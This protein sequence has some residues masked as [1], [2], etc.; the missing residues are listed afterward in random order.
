MSTSTP[1]PVHNRNQ[2]LGFPKSYAFVIGINHYPLLNAH[3]ISAVPDAVAL[4]RILKQEQGFDH[5]ELLLGAGPGVNTEALHSG[6]EGVI[7]HDDA[8]GE[9]IRNLLR[10]IRNA[11][12]S[13][14]INRGDSIV[15]YYAG[16]GKAGEFNQGPAGF[17]LPSDARPERAV[18]ESSSLIPMEEVFQT[19]ADLDCHHTLLILDC[20]FAGKFRQ[21]GQLTRSIGL[22]SFMPMYEERFERFKRERAWQ[23]LVSAGPHQTAADWMGDR[24]GPDASDHSPFAQALIDALGG[25]AE[26]K[27]S[28]KNLGDGVLTSQELFLYLWNQ[29]ESITSKNPDFD[30]QYPDLFPMGNHRGGQFIFFDPKNPL[31]FAHRV[32]RNPYKGLQVFEPEDSDLFF[33]RKAVTGELLKKLEQT[34]LLILTAP[35]ASGKSSLV[36]AGLFPALRDWKNEAGALSWAGCELLVLCPGAKAWSGAPALEKDGQKIK[37]DTGLEMVVAQ[38]LRPDKKQL[39]LIDQLENFFTDCTDPEEKSRFEAALIE[40]YREAPAKQLKIVLTLR[41][42]YEW[43]L[44][45]SG[46]GKA[47]QDQGEWMTSLYRLPAVQ[48]ADLR[49]ALT[50]PA[51]V[52]LFE[53]ETDQLMETILSEIGHAPGALPMLSFTMAQFY[54]KTDKDTR[55]FTP[56]TYREIGGVNGALSRYAD[57]VYAGLSPEKQAVLRK[58]MLRMVQVNSGAYGRRRVYVQPAHSFQDD[59]NREFLNEFDYP[60]HQ[61]ALVKEVLDLLEEKQLI[62]GGMDKTGI[63]LEP[64]HDSLIQHWNTAKQ[65]IEDF[66]VENLN[67][68]RQLWQAV[69]ENTLSGKDQDMG[70]NL[71]GAERN[72]GG[73][74]KLWDTNPK[75]NQVLGQL[76]RAAQP[77]METLSLDDLIDRNFSGISPEQ[78]EYFR[79]FWHECHEKKEFPDL[80]ALIL[81]GYSDKLLEWILE[82]GDHWLNQAEAAFVQQSWQKRIEDIVTLQKQRDE[83]IAD[84]EKVQTQIDSALTAIKSVDSSK[85]IL[86]QQIQADKVDP[87]N[88]DIKAQ[89]ILTALILSSA[90]TEVE[91]SIG[92]FDM[93][94]PREAIDD[95]LSQAH[96]GMGDWV[97]EMIAFK[98]DTGWYPLQK[99]EYGLNAISYLQFFLINAGFYPPR[100]RSWGIYGYETIAGLRLFQEYVRTV[101]AD[102]SIGIPDGKVGSKTWLHILKWVQSGK[103]GDYIAVS[104]DKKHTVFGTWMA[105]INKRKEVLQHTPSPTQQLIE[106]FPTETDTLKLNDWSV[107]PQDVHIIGIRRKAGKKE[108]NRPNDDLFILLINGRVFG[109]WGSTDP[110]A[111]MAGR[112]DEAYLAEGQ[113]RYRVGWFKGNDKEKVYK[114]LRPFGKGVLV[115]RDTDDDNALTQQDRSK[116]LD[117]TP[118]PTIVFHWTGSGS[119][120]WSGGANVIAGGSYMNHHGK[121]VD[122]R[123][124]ASSNLAGLAEDKTQG[125]YNV[126]M[127]LLTLSQAETIYF[128]LIAE[129]DLEIAPDIPGDFAEKLLRELNPEMQ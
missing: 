119:A 34:N 104:G 29:V 76:S 36:R 39:L 53:F 77:L 59:R 33:G 92:N 21:V 63:Y 97:R 81:S 6:L 88:N 67:I 1:R 115:F 54:Q 13:P 60:D 93:D 79:S 15:F 35:S 73:F 124:F 78:Q 43:L 18:L 72:P 90:G 69:L 38:R 10:R 56:A 128:T 14:Q 82:K 11:Q 45:T 83:A 75:L 57:E 68:Q 91:I 129:E 22:T 61:D 31:N 96:H 4:A 87:G 40:L 44:E 3:L 105:V 9:T 98:M 62:L 114:A 28:G 5:V 80:N 100:H 116:G 19:L 32:L 101:D 47:L 23:V 17:L 20:C 111:K 89:L 25:K 122:C 120:N 42:D 7:V 125:A 85:G 117:P 65:W 71:Y 2:L 37:H 8:S 66:G 48:P 113:H 126:F 127:D 12:E 27:P 49:E 102:A 95:Y 26:L 24:S 107:S 86:R 50:G 112:P 108:T 99:F 103:K 55:V 84:K 110:N 109:F 30:I 58:L 94:V 64:V 74:S 46:L 118:N 51:E 41:S 121:V 52:E 123:A 70:N 106:A 16:H